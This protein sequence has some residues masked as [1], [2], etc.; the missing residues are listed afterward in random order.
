MKF[1]AQKEVMVNDTKANTSFGMLQL[2]P[3]ISVVEIKTNT[4]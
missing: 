4:F 2:L 3:G 1:S